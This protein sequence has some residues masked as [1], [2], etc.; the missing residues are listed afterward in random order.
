MAPADQAGIRDGMMRRAERAARD[1]GL[2]VREHA[3]HAENL[4]GLDGLLEGDGRQDR[5]KPLRQHGLTRAGRAD[6]DEIVPAGS[7]DLERPLGV[8]LPAHLGIVHVE[9]V[10]AVEHG[11]NVGLLR[12]MAV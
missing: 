4:G 6:H 7:R 2:T 8:L 1:E 10:F 5:R 11:V 3:D 9:G 12:S